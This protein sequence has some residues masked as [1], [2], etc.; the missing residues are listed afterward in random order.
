MSQLSAAQMQQMWAAGFAPGLP[1]EAMAQF[2]EA[3]KALAKHAAPPAAKPSQAEG[4]ELP[5]KGSEVL[6][7]SVKR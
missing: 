3:Q 1:P 7:L 5:P 6:D 2:L 4:R